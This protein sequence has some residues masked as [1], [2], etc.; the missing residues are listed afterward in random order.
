MRLLGF[1]RVRGGGGVVLCGGVFG[2]GVVGF[3]GGFLEWE[4]VGLVIERRGRELGVSVGICFF[5]FF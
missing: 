5:E 2:V 1:G 4:G 3:G